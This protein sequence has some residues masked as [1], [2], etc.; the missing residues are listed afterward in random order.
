MRISRKVNNCNSRTPIS[1]YD[2]TR[3]PFVDR[4]F[5]RFVGARIL[6]LKI[7]P[8]YKLLT[9]MSLISWC[10]DLGL[11]IISTF[12]SFALMKRLWW[13]YDLIYFTIGFFI[14]INS[15][16]KK[17]ICPTNLWKRNR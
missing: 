11:I 5:T 10:G 13:K 3:G 17:Q 2:G 9:K 16:L 15:I 4:V 14:A 7:L 12:N 1:G 8:S 6:I